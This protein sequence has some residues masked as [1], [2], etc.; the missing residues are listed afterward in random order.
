MTVF[1]KRDG[2]R[3][4]GIHPE[5]VAKLEIIFKTMQAFGHPMFVVS[6][7]RTD[8]EQQALYAQGRTKPG[9]IVT[10]IDGII[11]RS[12]H[13]LN[14]VTGFGHAVDCAFINRPET[15]GNDT[16]SE[17]EPWNVYGTIAEFLELNWGGR[18]KS[19]VDRPHLELR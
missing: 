15:P 16:W 13:Q 17:D 11:K 4:L 12:N 2:I 7:I 1:S 14:K 8:E 18:W 5:L 3:L 19:L 10:N 6:G 9:K